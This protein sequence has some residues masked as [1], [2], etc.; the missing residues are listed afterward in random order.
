MTPKAPLQAELTMAEPST[1]L[2]AL[3][4]ENE[5]TDKVVATVEQLV[6]AQIAQEVADRTES[7]SAPPAV[8]APVVRKTKATLPS[9]MKVK[10]K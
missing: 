6:A 1:R 3:T 5:A 4:F 8:A 9:P 7:P 2:A 10:K